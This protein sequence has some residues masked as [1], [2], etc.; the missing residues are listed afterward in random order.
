MYKQ[1]TKATSRWSWKPKQPSASLIYA[2]ITQLSIFTLESPSGFRQTFASHNGC[3]TGTIRKQRH[4][5]TDL[6]HLPVCKRRSE[7]SV[8]SLWY[9]HC[10][11]IRY[12][13][14]HC[15]SAALLLA[16]PWLNPFCV[17]TYSLANAKSIQR[18]MW[19]SSEESARQTTPC[20][21]RILRNLRGPE[22]SGRLQSA[23]TYNRFI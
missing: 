5:I 20:T 13:L 15:V 14:N 2:H 16:V 12:L 10:D 17:L 21:H 1:D 23:R 11:T 8:V 19:C 3:T 22:R 6:R 4:P 7:G 9:R 18:W